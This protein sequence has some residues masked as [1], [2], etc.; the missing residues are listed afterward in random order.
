[1]PDGKHAYYFDD[2][3]VTANHF[4]AFDYI[5]DHAAD[6]LTEDMV[7]QLHGILFFGTAAALDETFAI[8]DYKRIPNIIRA[9]TE[10]A[11]PIR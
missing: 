5:L 9:G 10:A 7:T 3:V 1:M 6:A 2:L 11:A 8:D 4:R